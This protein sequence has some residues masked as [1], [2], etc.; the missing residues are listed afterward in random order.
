[1]LVNGPIQL[2][3]GPTLQSTGPDVSL[4]RGRPSRREGEYTFHHV[5]LAPAVQHRL[6]QG[7]RCEAKQQANK[8]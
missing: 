6:G 8:C 4:V 1:M 5:E 3:R 7:V 2:S